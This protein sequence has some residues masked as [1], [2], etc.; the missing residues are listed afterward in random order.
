MEGI[1]Y[2][3]AAVVL[4]ALLILIVLAISFIRRAETT[5]EHANRVIQ[6]S[7]D[8]IARLTEQLPTLLA[9]I[10]QLSYNATRTLDNA[11][12]QL[13]VL[14]VTLENFRQVSQRIYELEQR[15]QTKIEGPLMDVAKIIAG[16]NKA[17]K[18]FTDVFN[19]R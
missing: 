8:L 6:Q 19:R 7:Q 11:D 15:L 14:G 18:T 4:I 10:E 16:L 1:L 13:T 12:R 3:I 9:S 17:V 5:A 2:G